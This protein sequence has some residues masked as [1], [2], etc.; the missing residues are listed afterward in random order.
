M[1]LFQKT[2]DG[3][4]ESGVTGYFFIEI[5]SLFSIVLLNFKSSSRDAFHSHAFSA[6]T[7]WLRG[8]VIERIL[9][10]GDHVWRA[11]QLKFTPRECFHKVEPSGSAWALSLRGPWADTW[12][13]FKQGRFVTLTHGRK[14]V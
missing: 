12:Q 1:R 11:G 2:C 5:K 10:G 7:L 3:G 6:L 4:P 14:E 13:E 8:Q 9:E